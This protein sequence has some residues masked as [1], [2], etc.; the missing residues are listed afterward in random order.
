MATDMPELLGNRFR[1]DRLIAEGGMARVY[2]GTDTVLGRVVAV[3]VLS[4]SLAGD[5]S[6]VARFQREARAVASLNH[7]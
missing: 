1:I 7:P 2:E 3:K 6:F 5:P 4:A